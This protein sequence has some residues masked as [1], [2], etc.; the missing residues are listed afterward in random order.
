MRLT[1]LH[2]SDLHANLH[3]W[4]YFTGSP[5]EH[6]LAK[7]ATLIKEVRASSQDPVLLIDRRRHHSGIPL[8]HLLRPGGAGALSSPP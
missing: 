6:G 1:I 8:R 3:P 2:T 4:N 7:V 5:A